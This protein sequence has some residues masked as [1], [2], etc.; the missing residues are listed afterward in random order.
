MKV[1]VIL[2]NILLSK[3]AYLAI[4]SPHRKLLVNRIDSEQRHK[5]E[6]RILGNNDSMKM[7]GFA[8]VGFILGFVFISSLLRNFGGINHKQQILDHLEKSGKLKTRKLVLKTYSVVSKI[9]DKAKVRNHSI[10]RILKNKKIWKKFLSNKQLMKKT[11]RIGN[12][13]YV[14]LMNQPLRIQ[15]KLVKGFRTSTIPRQL[16]SRKLQDKD[17]GVFGTCGEY[18]CASIFMAM[19][20]LGA[21]MGFITKWNEQAMVDSKLN[22]KLGFNPNPESGDKGRKLGVLSDLV[23]QIG[24]FT[25]LNSSKSKKSSGS[26]FIQNL[27]VKFLTGQSNRKQ[28]KIANIFSNIFSI[29]PKNIKNMLKAGTFS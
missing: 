9:L 18:F 1:Y 28:K 8:V 5:S 12:I 19:F 15:R 11:M 23:K 2:M 13:G 6:D 29:L 26:N 20:A 4:L 21:F 7:G 22:A 24:S 3:V 16:F 27:G 14:N 17:D 10:E 25:A